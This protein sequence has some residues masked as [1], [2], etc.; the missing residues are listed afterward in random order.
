[1][2]AASL[3]LLDNDQQLTSEKFLLSEE[4]SEW[5]I[6]IGF[7]DHFNDVHGTFF[8]HYE[9]WILSI[10]LLPTMRNYFFEL[11]ENVKFL[12]VKTITFQYGWDDK[13]EALYCSADVESIL[14]EIERVCFF[15]NKAIS[16]NS[17]I[18]FQL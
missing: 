15:I 8:G 16:S 1:M 5:L 9:E 7:W 3:F 6:N 14:I 17:E 11:V 4:V 12:D 2:H 10:D 18:F 13:K